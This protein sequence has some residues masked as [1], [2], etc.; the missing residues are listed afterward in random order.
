M[1]EG[2]EGA[3]CWAGA[4]CGVSKVVWQRKV[5]VRKVWGLRSERGVVRQVF[6][7]R[8]RVQE[9]KRRQEEVLVRLSGKFGREE[10]RGVAKEKSLVDTTLKDL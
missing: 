2:R 6:A 4:L 1:R 9:G 7:E 8:K 3:G 5:V 10:R